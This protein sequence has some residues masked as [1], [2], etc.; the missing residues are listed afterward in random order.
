MSNLLQTGAAFLAAQLEAH[1]SE[2]VTVQRG[3]GTV[4]ADV[5]GS[6]GK[7]NTE[8]DGQNGSYV[9]SHIIDFIVSVENY[10]SALGTPQSDD[11][12]TRTTGAKFKV[13]EVSGE[14]EFRYTDAFRTQYRIHL[15]EVL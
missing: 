13:C 7:T 10:P 2:N 9:R 6:F 12:L 14:G 11:L 4:Y 3:N 15:E 5:S 1:A 8:V